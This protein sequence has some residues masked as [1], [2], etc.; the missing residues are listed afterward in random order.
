MITRVS[1]ATFSNAHILMCLTTLFWAGN[2]VLARGVAGHFPPIALAWF[3]WTLAFLI[4]APF[5]LKYVREDWPVIKANLPIL[6]FLGI[7]SVGAF[8]TLS[9]IGLNYTT[10]I[11]GLI[12]QSSGPIVIAIAAFLIFRDRVTILQSIGILTS[13]LGVLVVIARGDFSIL[14]SLTFNVGDIWIFAAMMVWALYT[15]FLRLRP[16][17][18]WQSL[19]SVTFFI[20]AIFITPFFLWEYINGGRVIFDQKSILSIAYVCIFPSI[21]S[22]IFYNR[23]VELIGANRAGAYLHMAP[24]FGTIMAIALLGEELKIF[25]IT[26]LAMILIGVFMASRK[27]KGSS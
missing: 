12:L 19:A 13:L 20:G 8:N 18:H 21:L 17:I 22:Y 25:H 1:A 15:V 14:Q 5:T 3:R 7:M 24:F 23:S 26:G 11:N 9:Y 2:F 10:A 27:A 6:T 4:F 16:K